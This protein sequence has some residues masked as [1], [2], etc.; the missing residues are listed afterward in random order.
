MSPPPLRSVVK[1]MRQPSAEIQ[2]GALCDPPMSNAVSCVGAPPLEGIYVVEVD[3]LGPAVASVGPHT[4]GAEISFGERSR[5][6]WYVTLGQTVAPGILLS[7][8]SCDRGTATA[9]PFNTTP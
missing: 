6:E 5:S 7:V 2:P 3:G 9:I 4:V 8:P 1:Y